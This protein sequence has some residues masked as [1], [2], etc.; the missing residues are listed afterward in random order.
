M[1]D[2]NSGRALRNVL[3]SWDE[4]PDFMK[5]S[6]VRPYWEILNRRRAQLAVKRACD[7]IMS[8]V[9]IVILMIPM[10]FIAIAIKLGSPGPTLYRQI[11]ITQYG[12]RFWICKFRTMY[13]ESGRIENRGQIGAAITVANDSRVTKLGKVLRRYRLDEFPQLFNVLAGDM[14]FVGTRPEVPQYVEKYKAEWISTLLLPAGI[15]SECSI[16]YKNEDLLLGGSIDVGRTYLEEVLPAKMKWNLISVK[17]FSLLGE[18]V[19]MLR[20]VLTVLGKDYN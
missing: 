17:R 10:C 6:E 18:F 9:L 12:R 7:V 15:T 20:T 2:I 14:S 1:N 5:V 8:S 16:R 13:D 11:R 19:T 3:L 4:L